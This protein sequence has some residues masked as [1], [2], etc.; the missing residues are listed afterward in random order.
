MNQ[1]N[2]I[3]I[4]RALAVYTSKS[5]RKMTVEELAKKVMPNVEPET[6][7]VYLVKWNKGDRIERL[8]PAHIRTIMMV[9][10]CDANDLYE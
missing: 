9:T 3:N 10:G 7:R 4:D 6:A 2:R 1:A 8:R 5:G